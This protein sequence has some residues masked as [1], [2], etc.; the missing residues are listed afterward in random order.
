MSGYFKNIKELQSEAVASLERLVCASA[1]S[2]CIHALRLELL[3][4]AI[5]RVQ[6]DPKTYSHECRNPGTPEDP[7]YSLTPILERVLQLLY[8][9]PTGANGLTPEAIDKVTLFCRCLMV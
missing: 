5:T 7:V 1:K 8:E 3:T 9:W 2:Y 4:K 6:L